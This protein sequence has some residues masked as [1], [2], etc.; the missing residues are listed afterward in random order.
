M[1]SVKTKLRSV[2]AIAIILVGIIPLTGCGER[3]IEQIL[4]N[5]LI[6]LRSARQVSTTQHRYGRLETPAYRARLRFFE[7]VNKDVDTIADEIATLGS[8]TPENKG[9]V[10]AK[11][12]ALAAKLGNGIATGNFG[13]KNPLKQQEYINHLAVMR[14]SVLA[15]QAAI[16][17]V[18]KPTPVEELTVKEPGSKEIEAAKKGGTE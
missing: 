14:A 2:V 18:K 11:L 13:V 7:G 1:F 12:D 15:V 4:G 6:A 3:P 8:I 17:I 5:G 10:F 9:E 16:N